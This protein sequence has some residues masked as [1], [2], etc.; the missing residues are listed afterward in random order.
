MSDRP[1]PP[2]SL[3]ENQFA[4]RR[5]VL[6]LCAQS[7]WSALNEFILPDGRR[8]DVMALMPDGRLACI[9]I[10]SGPLDFRLD[11]KWPNYRAWCDVLYFAVDTA[12]PLALLPVDTGVM[13]VATSDRILP[14]IVPEA[15]VLRAPPSHPLSPARRRI[16]VTLFARVAADRLM[17]LED[18]MM[19]AS[20]RSARRV[21]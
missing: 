21:D 9:E 14:G 4:I 5:G 16:L 2:P 11:M 20:L 7:A 15:A 17:R 8:A 12:F 19:S 3:P 6:A 13:T 10:K 18:P 1:A